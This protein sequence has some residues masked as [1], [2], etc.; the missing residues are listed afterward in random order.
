MFEPSDQPRIFGLPPG[1][2]FPQ[3]L[4]DGLTA[5]GAGHPPEALARA[6]LI[7][8]TRRMARRIRTLF[9]AGPAL[10]LP[11]VSLVTDLA[12]DWALHDIPPAVSPLRRRLE[13]TQLVSGLLERKPDLA[14]RSALYDLADSLAGLMDEMHGEGVAPDVIGALDVTDQ[15]GHW[16]RI[17]AFL[18]I[19]RQVFDDTPGAPDAEERQRRV[20]LHLI[21]RWE[22]KPPEHPVILAG[23][24]GSRGTTLM[25]MQ[26]IARLPQGA[27]V[28]PGFD[29]DMPADIWPALQDDAEGALPAEDHPQFRFHRLLGSLG[30]NLAAVKP[31][32]DTPA[33]N[34]LRNRL[35][36][37]ALRPAPVTDQWLRD[38]P[39]MQD[40]APATDSITL[41]EAPS[42][43]I[44]ALTIAMRL[45]KAAEEG[46]TA[47]LI[48]PDRTLTRQVAAALDR[49]NIRPDDSAGQ[50]LHLSPPGRFLRHVAD[51]FRNRLTSQHLLTILKHPLAHSGGE[52]G[53]H[54][55]MTREL[56]LYL[57]EKGVPYP[58]GQTLHTWAAGRKEP[59]AQPWATWVSACLTDQH[60]PGAAPLIAQVERHLTLAERIADGSTPTG[61]S[62][63]WKE[64][65]GR[66]AQDVTDDLTA[67]APHGGEI[68]AQDYAALFHAIL[69]RTEVRNPDEPHP[70]ILIWG[71]LEARVQGADL[72]ILAGLNEGSW[73]Q[74]P[75]P[76]PWL[77]RALRHQAGLLLPERRIGLSAHDFQQ[78]VAA[79]EVWLT[80]SIRS[81]DAETVAA[82]WINRLTNLLAGLPDQGGKQALADMR[83]RGMH[84]MRLAAALEDPTPQDPAPRPAPCPPKAARP[85]RLSVTQIKTLIR[86]PYAIYARHVLRLDP[87]NPMMRAPDALL[88]GIVLHD[89]LEDFIRESAEDPAL[90]TRER[91]MA[92]TVSVLAE[93]VP[94]AEA[95]ATWLARLERV[96]DW[97]VETEHARR[98]LAQPAAFEAKGKAE[99]ATLGFTLTGKAD[100]ID[101]DEAGHLHIYD[102]K[103]GAPPSKDQQTHFD[104][105][106]LLEAAMAERAG[107]EGLPPATVARALF[108]GLGGMP[109]EVPAPLENEPTAK[110]WAEFETL[111]A[112]YL[113]PAT[114][115]TARRAVHSKSDFA[116]YDQLSRFGEWDITDD[117]DRQEVK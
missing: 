103:T 70:H 19:V 46:V 25:L 54:L 10:L 8:N 38:G 40:V 22:A 69:A 86:D 99:I 43:R 35:I 14:P 90:C 37:L 84:W 80:R 12:H 74:V 115:Y 114:G 3:A 117:P 73:P 47:A 55:R 110:V 13:L 113:D 64:N 23:S 59:F 82:R 1:V 112:A 65:A 61:Q 51:L 92:K 101:R 31:W 108:I 95:R 17:L 94:W 71:T 26:A 88:R 91:L 18:D 42:T 36:S 41:L 2:D 49:W 34:P 4:I 28:L 104:K 85:H 83:A 9:D 29:F 58:D 20:V 102:Y 6:H 53:A 56:E 39:A 111:I 7:V 44:E 57:R 48:T 66:K 116:A 96:A 30:L 77:N 105:Q 45:R 21:E 67:Q 76:D 109:K 27:V 97:F 63:L 106:L 62:E 79:K 81:D 98:E 52:R 15:S 33:P 32:H 5:R 93:N 100:R 60:A 24:T 75:T 87:L 78:A 16:A 72:V 107:F 68:G 89:V 11:R 50:P